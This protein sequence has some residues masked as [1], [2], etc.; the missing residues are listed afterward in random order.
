MFSIKHKIHGWLKD[1]ERES[2]AITTAARRRDTS[3]SSRII[4]SRNSSGKS[5]KSSRSTFGRSSTSIKDQAIVEKMK[6]AE[7]LAEQKY[8]ERRNVSEFE[9]ESLRIQQK[10]EKAKARAKMLD[11]EI[12]NENIEERKSDN[13]ENKIHSRNRYEDDQNLK[14]HVHWPENL[15]RKCNRLSCDPFVNINANAPKF[16]YEDIPIV[17]SSVNRGKKTCTK[18]AD[19]TNLF[20]QTTTDVLCQ[21]LRQQAAPQVDIEVFDGNLLNFKYFM[22]LLKEVVE[23][24]INDPKGRLTR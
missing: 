16:N 4:S 13:I 7:L 1:V 5:T 23:T 17:N 11:K 2:E 19:P 9:A 14:E 20:H 10:V 15:S 3:R 22:S 18:Q 12:E 8:I 21:L 24:K 6:V